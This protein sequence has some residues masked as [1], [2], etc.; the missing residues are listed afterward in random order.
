MKI[1]SRLREL[2]KFKN[3]TVDFRLRQFRFV[4]LRHQILV[5]IDFDS[6]EGRILLK[7]Y[8]EELALLNS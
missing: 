5:F 2:P 4:D 8:Q 6:E 7:E 1:K 3:Y